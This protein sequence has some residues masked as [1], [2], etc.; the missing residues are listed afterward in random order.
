MTIRWKWC[1]RKGIGL[2]CVFGLL[3][4]FALSVMSAINDAHLM[5]MAAQ[6][7]QRFAL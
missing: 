1:L 5:S 4:L 3:N 7:G 2:G 6:L